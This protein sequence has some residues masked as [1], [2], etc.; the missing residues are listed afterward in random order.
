MRRKAP[1]APVCAHAEFVCV[2]YF[3]L[4]NN[5]KHYDLWEA[6]WHSGNPALNDVGWYGTDRSR[7]VSSGL[8]DAAAD[9]V[10][11]EDT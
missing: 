4:H 3:M 10:T 1:K 7:S 8:W 11:P 2:A 9:Y 5:N 6:F